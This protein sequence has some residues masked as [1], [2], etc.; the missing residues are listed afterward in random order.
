MRWRSLGVLALLLA[1]AAAAYYALE[2]K[3]KKSE[4]AKQLLQADEKDVRR[5]PS[6]EARSTS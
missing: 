5:S 2:A 1:V 4:D 3:G 6:K